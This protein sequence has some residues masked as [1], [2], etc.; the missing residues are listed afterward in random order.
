MIA[1]VTPAGDGCI[2]LGS[3][4]PGTV[5]V[6]MIIIVRIIKSLSRVT[7]GIPL[8]FLSTMRPED[9][10]PL[11]T[12][13][14]YG[15]EP[16][17][18][19]ADLDVKAVA[20]KWFASFAH[21]METG[22]VDALI[23]LLV[24]DDH[25]Y[26]RDI[27]A[28]TWDFR[29]FSGVPKIKQFLSDRLAS[30]KLA[31]LKIEKPEFISLVQASPV[32]QWIQFHFEFK[33]G[34]V[35]NGVGWIRLIPVSTNT[36]VVWK[37]YS[38]LTQLDGLQGSPEKIGFLRD[39]DHYEGTWADDRAAESKF[40]NKDPVAL[41]VGGAQAG[42]AVAARLK[43]LGVSCVVMEKDD[44]IGGNWRTRYDDLTL[45][46]PV[47]YDHMPY[48]PFP[49]SWPVY[50]PARKLA[51]WLESYADALDL[52]VWTSST[53]DKASQDQ[54]S[55]LW[56][57]TVNTRK[58]D[59]AGI[60]QES[61]RVFKVKHLI[62]A[63]GLVPGKV[64]VPTYPGM[65]TFKGKAIHAFNHKRASEY[66][67]KK[68]VIVGACTSAH[69]IAAECVRHG[70]DI[71]MY[72]RSSTYTMSTK[73]GWK[74]IFAGV[75]E[76]NGPPIEIADIINASMP[77]PMMMEYAR[78]QVKTLAE[79]DKELLEG[80]HKAGFKTNLG[81]SNAGLF[82][83]VFSKGGGYYLDTG[84][85]QLIIDGKIKIKNG[86]QIDKF[87]EN[88]IQ[89]D[90]GTVLSADVVIFATGLGDFRAEMIRILGDETMKDVSPIWGLDDDGELQGSCRDIG[91]A[92]LWSIV[93]NLA[94][95]RASSKHLGLQIK[96]MEENIFGTRY[97]LQKA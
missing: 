46:D 26:W 60:V 52:D 95:C 57:V 82:P 11:P 42:L 45:H 40:E 49:P 85:S 19:P 41:V 33:V 92:G 62:F 61:Q 28:L 47:W 13:T 79:L 94:A 54:S 59:S 36:G 75:Y 5:A 58:I 93:G 97:S 30:S 48:L 4:F 21:S 72:Q 96:A 65:D 14:K 37:G 20:A 68:V 16:A 89:F 27:L 77:M 67:G 63:T 31:A 17:D 55:G 2:H 34:N 81:P 90:D 18:I 50:S 12:L 83:L 71:T 91:V 24:P 8:H 53:V 43:Y 80:L 35:G 44:R 3:H 70:L 87:I 51:N 32:L 76:E 39:T 73:N 9:T 78:A 7:C 56:H 29:T 15:L 66:A 10:F 38:I 25:A 84:A 6:L 86:G 88:G 69:D 23:D 74:V 22:D 1:R 64:A